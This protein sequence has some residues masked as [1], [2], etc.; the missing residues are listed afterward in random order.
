[1]PARSLISTRTACFADQW[2]R[3]PSIAIAE[4]VLSAGTTPT[5]WRGAPTGDADASIAEI[6]SA[7]NAIGSKPALS[8]AN[9]ATASNIGSTPLSARSTMPSGMAMTS[10]ASRGAGESSI[11]DVACV[12][13]TASAAA[14]DPSPFWI[15]GPSSTT[16]NPEPFVPPN[17]SSVAATY[18]DALFEADA[19]GLAA[20]SGACANAS[21]VEPS[22]QGAGTCPSRSSLTL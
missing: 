6:N 21:M 15:V 7:A 8:T 10:M 14:P 13:E 4:L 22:V 3:R 2:L 5:L 20:I 18:P 12:D 19:C 1:M 16:A 17:S 9:S 11:T